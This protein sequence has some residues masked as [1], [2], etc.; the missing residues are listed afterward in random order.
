M[1]YLAVLIVLFSTVAWADDCKPIET[2]LQKQV[3]TAF[4]VI[5][6]KREWDN[7]GRCHGISGLSRHQAGE[8]YYFNAPA[9]GAFP[10]VSACKALGPTTFNGETVQHYYAAT[11]DD[12][13][14]RTFLKL[15]VSLE[16]GNILK[17][18]ETSPNDETSL[19]YEYRNLDRFY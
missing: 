5:L 1:K 6:K 10:S 3:H 18:F 14:D 11:E 15:W 8:Q 16:T 9:S 2:A 4:R 19:Q 13:T 17:R 12:G 7:Q